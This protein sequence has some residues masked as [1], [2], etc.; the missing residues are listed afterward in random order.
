[1][2][3]EMVKNDI[4]SQPEVN[5]SD[6]CFIVK[7][8]GLPY[9]ATAHDVALFFSGCDIKGGKGEGVHFLFNPQSG[10]PTGECFVEFI[11]APDMRKALLQHHRYLGRRYLEVERC[12]DET[13]EQTLKTHGEEVRESCPIV[14]LRGLPFRT[15]DSEIEKLFSGLSINKM[16]I[17]KDPR[18]Q[19]AGDGYV[20]FDKD[21]DM[22]DA[23]N[24]HMEKIG[25]RYIEVFQAYNV[26]D[27]EE[28][29][30]SRPM[31]PL[32][33][34]TYHHG[35]QG[36]GY[37]GVYEGEWNAP[38]PHRMPPRPYHALRMRG[39]PFEATEQ[40]IAEFFDPIIPQHIQ[41]VFTRQGRPSGEAEVSFGN[42]NDLTTAL[43][44]D[45]EYLGNRYVELFNESNGNTGN[46]PV[47]YPGPPN[48]YPNRY[49]NAPPRG[50]RIPSRRYY[51]R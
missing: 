33:P 12:S 27:L 13:K 29:P 48:P 41:I 36:G 45:K 17:I 46:N 10:K 35:D 50:G 26:T 1:M 9:S 20:Q 28:M 4:A 40:D 34:W 11:S 5:H 43:L 22:K 15:T 44:K 42:Y 47:A 8:R 39:L 51:E 31:K 6:S 32:K 3:G 14:R 7:V 23:L 19:A 16:V 21:G 37:P 49:T 18:G 2:N 24:R 38:P 30:K 25:H